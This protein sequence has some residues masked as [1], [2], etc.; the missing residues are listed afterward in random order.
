MAA[1]PP[2]P[3][4]PVAAPTEPAA[5]SWNCRMRQGRKGGSVVCGRSPLGRFFGCDLC[6]PPPPAL[7][8]SPPDTRIRQ[9]QLER[10]A[11]FWRDEDTALARRDLGASRSGHGC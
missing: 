9:W 3:P 2:P 1:P 6:C 11:C 8:R 10:S 4:P 7:V 5:S